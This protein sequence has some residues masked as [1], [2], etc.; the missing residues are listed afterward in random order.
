MRQAPDDPRATS[1]HHLAALLAGLVAGLVVLGIGG[2]A[3]MT[4][5]RAAHG[6]QPVWSA[7]GTLQVVLPGA[8]LGP[9]AGL[10]LALLGTRL[11]G[12]P[13]RRGLAFGA[14]HGLLWVG[15]YFLR[16]AGPVE[17]AG[18]PWLGG[19]L[20]AG[21]LLAFGVAVAVLEDRWR[22]SLAGVSVP[23]AARLLVWVA[24]AAGFGAT[25]C[26]IVTR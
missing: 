8:L 17:L 16:P 2:R 22:A 5:I 11:R 7:A 3:A 10:A 23:L 15:L 6:F 4:L 19:A 26:I 25:S 1:P 9:G 18:S 12:G 14:L 13:L 24:A 20:F 21:L